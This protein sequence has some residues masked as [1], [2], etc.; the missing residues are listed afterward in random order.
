[1]KTIEIIGI[2][3]CLLV[4]CLCLFY[5]GNQ[6]KEVDLGAKEI[7]H[8]QGVDLTWDAPDNIGLAEPN[9]FSATQSWEKRKAKLTYPEE[10]LDVIY[11]DEPALGKLA[12]SLWGYEP[13]DIKFII[14]LIPTWPDYI[15]L[16]KDLVIEDPN[17]YEFFS[18]L[19]I[20][21]GTKIFF[22]DSND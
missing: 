2:L 21:K 19:T 4:T 7:I 6:E 22:R 18:Q 13:F 5:I 14:S 8:E 12:K 9:S 15:E 10:E 1:M 11:K 17:S 3:Y 20:L 16:E